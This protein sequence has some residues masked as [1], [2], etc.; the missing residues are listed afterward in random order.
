M[1]KSSTGAEFV[2]ESGAWRG[3]V[4]P[5]NA[6]GE[7]HPRRVTNNVTLTFPVRHSALR[8]HYYDARWRWNWSIWVIPYERAL[9]VE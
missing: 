9:G 6:D 2:S 1:L 3:C 4:K 7:H 8:R 5:C